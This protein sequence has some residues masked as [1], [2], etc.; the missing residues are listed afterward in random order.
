MHTDS[1]TDFQAWPWICLVITDLPADYQCSWAWL[2]SLGLSFSPGSCTVGLGSGCQGHCLCQPCHC[3]WLPAHLPLQSSWLSPLPDTGMASRTKRQLVFLC[4]TQGVITAM[5][6]QGEEKHEI[7]IF[8]SETFGSSF[9][10]N[11]KQNTNVPKLY[12]VLKCCWN[13]LTKKIHFGQEFFWCWKIVC[14]DLLTY[15]FTHV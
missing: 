3:T 2:L 14:Y 12:S 6:L 15:T 8:I 4:T 11:S 10:E 5:Y 7:A 1:R 13:C 9:I